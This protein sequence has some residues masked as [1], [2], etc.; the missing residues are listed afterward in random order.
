MIYDLHGTERNFVHKRVFGAAKSFVTSGFSPTAAATGFLTGGSGGRPTIRSAFVPRRQRQSVAERHTA[1]GHI[2]DPRTGMRSG[3]GGSISART[4][5][6]SSAPRPVT[7]LA[8]AAE[9]GERTAAP[10]V[11][12]RI[13]R[14]TNGLSFTG[15]ASSAPGCG[16]GFVFRNGRCVRRDRFEG[17]FVPS[18][19]RLVRP[20]LPQ[21]PEVAD[22]ARGQRRDFGEAVVGAFGMPA[23]VPEEEVRRMLVCP[24]GMVLG[25]DDLCYPKGVLSSRNLHRKWRRPPRAPVTAADAKAIRTAAKARDRVL[26]LAKSVG[27]HASK[28]RPA[29][30]PK[31]APHQHLLA[32]PALRVVHEETN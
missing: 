3:H 24:R 32:A 15:P 28:T 17:G 14:P 27:L 16:F 5:A 26:G 9:T 29:A 1:H 4:R 7:R 8:R 11:V 13:S 30:K 2:K 31:A 6:P 20:F 21:P 18:L 19:K 25:T 23:M 22:M 12:T 10:S